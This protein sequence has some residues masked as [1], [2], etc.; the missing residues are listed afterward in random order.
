MDAR[1]LDPGRGSGPGS[2]A[3]VGLDS[4]RAAAGL[5]TTCM[6]SAE[7]AKPDPALWRAQ[8]ILGPMKPLVLTGS[9]LALLASAACRS[10]EPS[11][12]ARDP[13]SERAKP[14]IRYYVIGDA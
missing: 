12:G 3:P 6:P 8:A 5:V 4:R 14:E 13:D 9:L 1:P 2:P 11:A 10:A 7:S